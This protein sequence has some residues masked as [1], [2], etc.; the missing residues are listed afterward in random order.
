M[1]HIRSRLSSRCLIVPNGAGLKDPWTAFLHNQ[2]FKI[3]GHNA[4]YLSC[5]DIMSYESV[6]NDDDEFERFLDHLVD[7]KIHVIED[8]LSSLSTVEILMYDHG[9]KQPDD[10]TSEPFFKGECD[11]A[12]DSKTGIASLSYIIW[13]DDKIVYSEIFSSIKCSSAVEAEIFAACALLHKAEELKINKLL[14]CSDSRTVAT[15]LS[16]ELLIGMKH[17]QRDLFLMLR[18]MRSR[19]KWLVATWKPR[20][21]MVFADDLAKIAKLS[22]TDSAEPY[23]RITSAKWSDHLRGFPVFRVERSP[24]TNTAAKKLGKV[25]LADSYGMHGESLYFVE[26]DEDMKLDCL[27][28]LTQRLQPKT[29]SVFVSNYDQKAESFKRQFETGYAFEKTFSDSGLHSMFMSTCI[30]HTCQAKR[31]IV[32]FD[33]TVPKHVYYRR[34]AFHVV[35]VTPSERKIMGDKIPELSALGYVYFNGVRFPLNDPEEEQNKKK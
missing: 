33:Y 29:M 35:L 17:L 4:S 23:I 9:L 30:K 24:S 22:T 31:L 21:L 10:G 7:K 34:D 20:E 12:Y 5:F 8:W 2:I 6:K 26:V 15:I 27:V 13:K 3:A 14:V 11:A 18:A 16:G 32:S 28:G 1:K 19:F 25:R